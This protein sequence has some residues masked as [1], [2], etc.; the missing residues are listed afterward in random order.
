MWRADPEGIPR[1]CAWAGRRTEANLRG[2]LGALPREQEGAFS[3]HPQV[4]NTSTVG[5]Q[6][7][8]ENPAFWSGFSPVATGG[9]LRLL[10]SRLRFD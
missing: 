3:F 7:L 4:R 1:R 6:R 5:S 2:S 10:T 9:Q 8:Q